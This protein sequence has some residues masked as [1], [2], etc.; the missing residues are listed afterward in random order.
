M[1][2]K[3]QHERTGE[4]ETGG[5]D[6]VAED[7]DSIRTTVSTSSSTGKASTIK[8]VVDRE[9]PPNNGGKSGNSKGDK[10]VVLEVNPSSDNKC[11]DSTEEKE[12]DVKGTLGGRQSKG[13]T[14]A[15]DTR[16]GGEGITALNDVEKGGGS[17]SR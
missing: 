12:G 4:D 1:E 10:E 9:E 8:R 2:D 16:T 17:R 11:K 15:K 5:K 13:D 6:A 7:S 14:G 3:S